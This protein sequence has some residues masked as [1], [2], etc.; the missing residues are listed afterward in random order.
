MR[1]AERSAVTAV[2]RLSEDI[3]FKQQEIK[4]DPT[5]RNI[6]KIW[7]SKMTIMCTCKISSLLADRPVPIYVTQ[8]RD[9]DAWIVAK[10][11]STE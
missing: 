5:G 4:Y 11:Q 7:K 2:Q 3:A 9:Q 8:E 6:C 10:I 1:G